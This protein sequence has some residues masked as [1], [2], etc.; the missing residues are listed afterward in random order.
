MS[1]DE[2][3]GILMG[4]L[5][6]PPLAEPRTLRF[7]SGQRTRTWNRN[8]VAIGLASGFAEPLESTSIHLIQATIAKLIAFFPDREFRPVDVDEFNRQCRFENE[9]IRDFLILH[10]C[11]TERRD[12]P[13][14]QYCANMQI[15]SQLADNIQLFLDS[16]RFFRD[17]DEMF[18]VTSWVQVLIGQHKVPTGY[19][20][21]VDLI[22]EQELVELGKSVRNV[23]AA[24]VEAMPTHEQ[25][26]ARHFQAPAVSP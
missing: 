17:A 11:A 8:V 7:T 20:P 19:H 23:I 25:F 21:A 4:S 15:P 13:F 24:C 16:G 14:W 12:S 6:G 9:R 26:I 3:T 10:Y 22:S 5:D 1:E 18:A 2:A